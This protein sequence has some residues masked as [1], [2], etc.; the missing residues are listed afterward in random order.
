MTYATTT[1]LSNATGISADLDDEALNAGYREVCAILGS[2]GFSAPASDNTLKEAE[3]HFAKA[4]LYTRYEL[5]G[6][7]ASIGDLSYGMSVS[8]AIKDHRDAGEKL[9]KQ[10]IFDHDT[11]PQYQRFYIK[12]VNG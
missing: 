3:L 6:T 4:W 9:V 11:R 1:E 10:Y 7:N 5:D 2:A 8:Q 12:K